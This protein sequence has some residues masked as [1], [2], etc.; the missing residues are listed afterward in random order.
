MLGWFANA[1]EVGRDAGR[2]ET[3]PRPGQPGGPEKVL[4]EA[5][6]IEEA[7]GIAIGA[8]SMC[9]NPPP[10]DQVFD[11]TRARH[12]CEELADRI[13]A[14]LQKAAEGGVV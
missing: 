6:D 4:D 8:A 3:E 2:R 7:V 1:I 9:W 11:S 13:E 5:S 12:I 10:G 14:E